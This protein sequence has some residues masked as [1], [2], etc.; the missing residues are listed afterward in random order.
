MDSEWQALASGFL[1]RK[2]PGSESIT[3]WLQFQCRISNLY[4]RRIGTGRESTESVENQ[5]KRNRAESYPVY[6]ANFPPRL[7]PTDR[8]SLSATVSVGSL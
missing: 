3:L 2:D 1:A 7:A 8:L 4:C 5:A 6:G